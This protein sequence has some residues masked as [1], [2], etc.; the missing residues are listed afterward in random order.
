MIKDGNWPVMVTLFTEDNQIDYSA[1]ER[2]VE[3]YKDNGVDGLFAV[4]QSSEM[5]YLTLEERIKLARFV[6][7]KVGSTMQVIASGHVSDKLEDQIEEI[8]QISA[9]G[10]DA[11]V[12]VSNRLASEDESDEVFKEN[13]EA[14]ISAVPDVPFGVYECPYPY[15]RLVSPKLLR[16]LADT[17]RFF[18]LKDTCCDA[19]QI[20]NRINAVKGT[21]LKI[22]NANTATLLESYR[23]GAS[24]YSGVMA[25]FHP[26]LYT[27][28]FKNW[29][30]QPERAEKMQAFLGMASM[31]E[32]QQY[33][34]NAKY[35][36]VLEGIGES[37]HSRSK[38]ATKFGVLQKKEMN[39]FRMM[40]DFIRD[41]L[42]TKKTLSL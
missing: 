21:N 20:K 2:L 29:Q 1:M 24:G 13:V 23:F 34:V 31:F 19:E 27:W 6:K 11:F 5:F 42:K 28:L 9:T 8:K 38:N 18:F 36:I 26:D 30:D 17:N 41:T 37:I 40:T 33:P 25:N 4:C 3:W 22:F 39:Q 10:I 12:L 32:L 7:E 15:K 14:I 35:N 16:W